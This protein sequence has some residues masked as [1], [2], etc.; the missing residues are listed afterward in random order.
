MHVQSRSRERLT[1]LVTRMPLV[2]MGR[3]FMH[4]KSICIREWLIT[5]VASIRFSFMNAIK[6]Y[7]RL[8]DLPHSLQAY[9]FRWWSPSLC[10]WKV[11]NLL[12]IS[13]HSLQGY[14][15]FS[16][17]ARTCAYKLSD[18]EKTT[19]NHICHTFTYYSAY[20]VAMSMI[21]KA[22]LTWIWWH[23]LHLYAAHSTHCRQTYADNWIYSDAHF[24]PMS[25]FS[26]Y[27]IRRWY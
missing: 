27:D 22:W 5:L 20:L 19:K 14:T 2:L 12:K 25:A 17:V 10:L 9:N 15:I 4:I 1:A 11:L 16:G 26:L 24:N 23:I 8:N 13:S 6:L 7:I 18:R 21:V 3:P